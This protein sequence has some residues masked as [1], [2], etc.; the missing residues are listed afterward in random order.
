MNL[1]LKPR[2]LWSG[3]FALL[4]VGMCNPLFAQ[5]LGGGRGA[6]QP[7]YIPQGYDDH[8]NMMDQLGVTKLRPGESGDN[9]ER[10]TEEKANPYKESMPDVLKFKDG[11]KVTSAD[12]WPKRRA[13]ILEEFEREIYGRIPANVPKV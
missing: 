1:I 10:F 4:A 9:Q 8:Q 6:P 13:E 5:G 11:T 3:C 7:A 2:V 12:Q